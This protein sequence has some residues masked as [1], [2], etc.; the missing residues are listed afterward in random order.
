MYAKC[1]LKMHWWQKYK[2]GIGLLCCMLVHIQLWNKFT[3]APHNNFI[4]LIKKIYPVTHDKNDF[5][6]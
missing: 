2:L 5:W 6:D 3:L 1:S 4:N